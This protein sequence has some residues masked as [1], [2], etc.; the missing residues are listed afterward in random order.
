MDNTIEANGPVT[1]IVNW[2]VRKGCEKDFESWRHDIE[3]AA[4][5]FP[6]HM[7]VNLILPDKIPGEYTV[8]FRFDTYEHLH[9]WQQSDIRRELLKKAEQFRDTEPTYKMENGLAFWFL[10]SGTPGA[11]PNWKMAVVTVLWVWPL[12]IFVPWLLIPIISDLPS[13]LAALVVTVGIVSSLTWIV[14][15]ILVKLFHPWLHTNHR[16]GDTKGGGGFTV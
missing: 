13:I 4:I 11:P 1:I 16:G 8:I 7:G 15:P 2:R 6:G 5:A 14:M 10:P 9:A 3:S 12:S